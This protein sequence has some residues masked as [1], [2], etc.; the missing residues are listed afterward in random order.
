[1]EIS[2]YIKKMKIVYDEFHLFIE[3]E[4]NEESKFGTLK[5]VLK[6]NIKS[7]DADDIQSFLNI[8]VKYSDNHHRNIVFF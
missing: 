7:D 1:M 4:D 6:D 8:I 2:Q 3:N 5:N